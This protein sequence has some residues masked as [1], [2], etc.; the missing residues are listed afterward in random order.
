MRIF[1]KFLMIV[2]WVL[3]YVEKNL[4][5]YSVMN[6]F[7]KFSNITKTKELGFHPQQIQ[8]IP[9]NLF[10]KKEK[11]HTKTLNLHILQSIYTTPQVK[12]N[13]I[14]IEHS[15]CIRY[16]EKQFMCIII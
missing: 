5:L 16:I 9:H 8:E 3:G 12:I 2:I 6:K 10:F 1:K 11:N 7:H 4:V 15:P 13:C 14:V